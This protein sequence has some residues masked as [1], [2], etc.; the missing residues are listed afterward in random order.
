M[1]IWSSGLVH[2]LISKARSNGQ[3]AQ[4]TSTSLRAPGK[5][6]RRPPRL[7]AEGQSQRPMFRKWPFST[8]ICGL[9]LDEIYNQ[10]CTNDPVLTPELLYH[11][12]SAAAGIT[13]VACGGCS[14]YFVPQINTRGAV[15]ADT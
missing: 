9:V 11:T 2:S 13:E 15:V 10:V 14:L 1:S 8:S 5:F 6:H 7:H 4:G 3:T 12:P